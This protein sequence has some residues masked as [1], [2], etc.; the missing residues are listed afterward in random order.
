MLHCTTMLSYIKVDLQI[1]IKE[2]KLKFVNSPRIF[3]RWRFLI[4]LAQRNIRFIQ[5]DSWLPVISYELF[6]NLVRLIKLIL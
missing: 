2:Y 3:N 6:S 4:I 5:W 1:N